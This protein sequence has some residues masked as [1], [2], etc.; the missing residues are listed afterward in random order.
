MI[1]FYHFAFFRWWFLLFLFA[2][3]AFW[4]KFCAIKIKMKRR[5][6]YIL[7]NLYNTHR[8]RF[9]SEQTRFTDSNVKWWTKNPCVNVISCLFQCLPKA[10]QQQLKNKKIKIQSIKTWIFLRFMLLLLLLLFVIFYLYSLLFGQWPTGIQTIEFIFVV[11]LLFVS[12]L[13]HF[14][15]R[16]SCR[17]IRKRFFSYCQ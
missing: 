5:R 6:L 2:S 12:F 3:F 17:A 11:V 14:C 15:C 16:H 7:H 1:H 4:L 13:E 8:I 9:Q 10:T